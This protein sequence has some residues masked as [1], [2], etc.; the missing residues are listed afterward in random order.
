MLA[1]T[2][3]LEITG[4]ATATEYYSH[5]YDEFKKIRNACYRYRYRKLTTCNNQC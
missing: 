4:T 1:G 5:N 3:T 2:G